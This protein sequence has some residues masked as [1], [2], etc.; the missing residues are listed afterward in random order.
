[1]ENQKE[2]CPKCGCNEIGTGRQSGDAR[3]FPVG[4]FFVLGSLITYRI[5]TDCGYVMESYV[6]NPS[7]F[8]D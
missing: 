7:K 4:K 2:Q 3:V 5:C 8:K 1:M 6:E